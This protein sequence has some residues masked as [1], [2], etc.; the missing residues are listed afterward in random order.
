LKWLSNIILGTI[1][2]V[3]ESETSKPVV[4]LFVGKPPGNMSKQD[5]EGTLNIIALLAAK[6]VEMGVTSV[7][8]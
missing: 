1:T 8:K 3:Q 7:S 2:I 4:G 5:W 6:Q